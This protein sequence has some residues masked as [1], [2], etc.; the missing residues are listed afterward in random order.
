M[1][2]QR[3]TTENPY[4]SLSEDLYSLG[5]L[6]KEING[7]LNFI[8]KYVR[9]QVLLISKGFLNLGGKEKISGYIFIQCVNDVCNIE[10][11][12]SFR[13]KLENIVKQYAEGNYMEV[14]P[15]LIARDFSTDVIK[16]VD[17]YNTF[18]KRKNL[19]LYKY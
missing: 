5:I 3:I 18:Q 1:N 12:K 19:R 2:I 16:F 11:I 15:I 14:D 10:I 13:K 6:S 7:N 17:E 8:K 4:K 9:D